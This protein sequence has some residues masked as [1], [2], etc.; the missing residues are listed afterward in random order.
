MAKKATKVIVYGKQQGN[1]KIEFVK[2]LRTNYEFQ[3]GCMKDLED[4]DNIELIC[5]NYD[6][7]D[8]DSLDLMFAYDNDGERSDG[9]LYLGYFNDGVI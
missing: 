5:K 2:E 3:D 6:G 1:K 8:N 4:W 9:V 7:G